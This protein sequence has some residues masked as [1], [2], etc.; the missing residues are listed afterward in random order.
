M[1][2]AL[3]LVLFSEGGPIEMLQWLTLTLAAGVSFSLYGNFCHLNE[4]YFNKKYISRFWLIMGI[5]LMLMILEDAGNMRHWIRF[6]FHYI[7][8][9]NAAKFAELIYFGLL[10]LLPLAAVFLYGRY[11]LFAKITTLYLFGGFAFYGFAV[12]GSALRYYWYQAAGQWL[13]YDVF[14]GSMVIVEWGSQPHYFWLMDFW[15]E[16]SIEFMGATLLAA[17]AL[18][19]SAEFSKTRIKTRLESRGRESNSELAP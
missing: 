4:D 13:H 12:I 5:A 8:G 3:W 18:H 1:F 2:F 6:F 14:D 17:A 15:I 10:A 7:F 11:I 9:G 19:F 16:E